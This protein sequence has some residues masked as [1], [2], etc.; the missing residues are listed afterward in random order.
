MPRL[1]QVTRSEASPEIAAMYDAVFGVGRDPV[2]EPGTSTGTPGDWWTTMALAPELLTTFTQ[3]FA[4][5]NRA[6]REL[7]PRL[8]ELALV[9]TG[10]VAESRFVF[11]QHSKVARA[12]GVPAEKVA[13]VPGW[14]SSNLFA[15]DERAVLA[16]VD[17]LVL[18][19]GR[20]SDATFHALRSVLSEVAVFELTVV[21]TTYQQHAA[22]T[23]ALRLEYDNVEERVTEVPAPDGFREESLLALMQGE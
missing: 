17:E 21:A 14:A 22:I 19:R 15:D 10:F 7:E 23:R 3:Q 4:L 16:Y 6:E 2:S 18:Q 11:S 20:V 5:F 13:A 12:C 9:R 8:R 1:T